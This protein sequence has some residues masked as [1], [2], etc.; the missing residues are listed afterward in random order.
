MSSKRW[1][2]WS[3]GIALFCLISLFAC[4]GGMLW[5]IQARD[6]DVTGD[7]KHPT[8]YIKGAEYILQEDVFLDRYSSVTTQS[9]TSLTVSEYDNGPPPYARDYRGVIR[10]GAT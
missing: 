6:Y 10:K 8:D 5:W 1:M 4:C 2:G 9:Q 7:P 3:A